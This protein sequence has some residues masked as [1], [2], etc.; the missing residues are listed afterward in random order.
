MTIEEKIFQRK[1]LIPKQMLECCFI[2]TGLGFIWESDFMDGDLHTIL[3]VSD[4]YPVS[5]KVIDKMA[6]EEYTPIRIETRTGSYINSVRIAY[7][8]LLIDLSKDCC[9]DVLFTSDRAN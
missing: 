6:D 8:D 5:G 2:K 3:V 7:E 1:G 9:E 4:K